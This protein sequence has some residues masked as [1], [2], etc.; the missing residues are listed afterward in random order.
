VIL[1]SGAEAQL[2]GRTIVAG[3]TVSAY[4]ESNQGA[5]FGFQEIESGAVI[6]T[7]DELVKSGGILAVGRRRGERHQRLQ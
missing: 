1:A 2:A 4:V 6:D 7:L 5:I 3:V